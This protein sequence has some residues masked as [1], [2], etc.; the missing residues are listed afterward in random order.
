MAKSSNIKVTALYTRL[1]R[2]DELQGESN[3]ITNQK[4]YLEE[5]AKQNGFN[6]IVHFSDDGY[7]GVDFNR[8]A[9]KQMIAE[10]EKGNVAQIICKDL[11]R[12]GRNYLKVGFY[13][14][15]MFPEKDVRFI[16]INNGVDSSKQES[17]DFTPFLNIMNEWYSKDT[18][19]KIRAVFKARMKE[20]KRCSGAI[21]YGFY[22]KADDKNTLYVD[23]EAAKVVKQ[24]FQMITEG[25]GVNHIARTLSE[26]KVL[27]PSAYAELNH[28]SDCRSNSYQDPYKWSS[29]A[30][31]YIL[32]KREYMGHTVLGKTICENF[33]TKKRRKATED[34]LIIFENTHP[35]IVSEETWHNAQRLKRKVR[36]TVRNKPLSHLLS[37]VLYCADCGARMTYRSPEANHRKDGKTYDSD[38]AFV[39]G[40]YR[41]LHR[42]CTIHFTKSSA[43]ET[44]IKTAISNVSTYVLTDKKEFIERVKLLS[45]THH[46]EQT[47]SDKKE[48][49][50]AKKRIAE[51]DLLVKKLYEG[52]AI[53]K[54]PDN[55]FERLLA[56]YD[57]EH[58][59]LTNRIAEIETVV[60][61]IASQTV[62]TDKFIA[63]VKKYK[64]FDELT[65]TILNEFIEKIIVHEATGGRTRLRQQQIDIYFNFIGK[66]E[67]P[68]VELSEEELVAQAKE[69]ERIVKDIET[70]RREAKVQKE[71]KKAKLLEEAKQKLDKGA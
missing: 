44:L 17:N 22:R 41:N 40:D 51:L 56:D 33:K 16:A 11:S 48:L 26:N 32:Q 10:V 3:S 42:N 71:R 8:P 70:N 13:T 18:S 68:Q 27:I 4:A 6:R 49:A 30:V 62:K 36:R 55:H 64:D 61:E 28:P 57:D 50:T 34:E 54:I 69:R 45:D 20:G 38:S 43:I 7:S 2:D 52:N 46:E 35:A 23:E 58:Q 25:Y 1:S 5:F 60:N 9:F 47:K 65:P 31:S 67:L 14:E 29:T 15:I 59:A 24:I 63:L 39:C 12:F 21:P 19:N 53:G 37:G 66:F